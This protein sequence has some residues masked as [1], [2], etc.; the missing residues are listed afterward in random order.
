MEDLNC[1]PD[2]LKNSV[3]KVEN[4]MRELLDD[5]LYLLLQ[6]YKKSNRKFR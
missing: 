4:C 2:E 5:G 6:R 1:N 3:D